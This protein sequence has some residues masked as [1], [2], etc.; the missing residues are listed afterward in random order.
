MT[1]PMAAAAAL[2]TLLAGCASRAPEIPTLPEEAPKA[3]YVYATQSLMRGVR[4]DHNSIPRA[5][6]TAILT[7]NYSLECLKG[8]KPSAA[9]HYA[10]AKK[11]LD[12]KF[13]VAPIYYDNPRERGMWIKTARRLV[14]AK[15]GCQ[16]VGFREETKT[17][18]PQAVLRFILTNKVLPLK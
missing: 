9:Q 11:L 3:S 16:V 6:P 18:D 5:R 14:V 4:G 17:T 12:D 15:T 8:G 2:L 7:V 1:Y 13:K 10:A